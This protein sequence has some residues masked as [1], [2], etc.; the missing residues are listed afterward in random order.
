MKGLDRT[1]LFVACGALFLVA[2]VMLGNYYELDKSAWAAWVQ[3]VGSVIAIVATVG[4][5]E[6][7]H[8]KGEQEKERRHE[9]MVASAM[10]F[11]RSAVGKIGEMADALRISDVSS[12][13]M[14]RLRAELA[15]IRWALESIP[16]AEISS[17]EHDLAETLTTVLSAVI[18]CYELADL[19]VQKNGE[20]EFQAHVISDRYSDPLYAVLG[21][22]IDRTAGYSM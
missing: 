14:S 3:A 13:D 4:V 15:G 6:L 20:D 21:E 8:S 10:R 1:P 19:I 9:S 18:W 16:L 12:E 11:A 22:L 17:R 5:V 2:A 7:Q